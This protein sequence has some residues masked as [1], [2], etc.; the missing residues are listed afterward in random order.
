MLS[1]GLGCRAVSPAL[2]GLVDDRP[3]GDGQGTPVHKSSSTYT[4]RTRPVP[5]LRGAVY[6]TVPEFAEA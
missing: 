5:Y 6:V 2:S 3:A 4:P 1:P